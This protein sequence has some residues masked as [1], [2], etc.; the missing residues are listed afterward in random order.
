MLK[1]DTAKS[2]YFNEFLRFNDGLLIDFIAEQE[3]IDKIEAAKKVKAFVDNA[4]KLLSNNKSVDLPGL[5]TLY[6]DVNE[7]IQLKTSD[8][9][10][11]QTTK[12]A[13]PVTEAP[14]R[15]ILFELEKT[16]PAVNQTRAP[17]PELVSPRPSQSPDIKPKDEPMTGHP[18]KE[19]KPVT[20]PQSTKEIQ[21]SEVKANKTQS[22]PKKDNVV[23]D[24]VPTTTRRMVIVGILGVL[25]I[26]AIIYFAFFHSFKKDSGANQNITIGGDSTTGKKDTL[27]KAKLVDVS[28][29]NQA[30]GN[31]ENI[32]RK[33][34]AKT[35]PTTK[36][37][38]NKP[39]VAPVAASKVEAKSVTTGKRFYIIAGTFSL[40]SNADKMFKKLKEQGF[41]PDKI[42]NDT[43]NVFYISFS[44]FADKASATEEMKKIRS[45]GS[46]AWIYAN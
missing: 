16:E 5:G 28:S 17:E 7:K 21:P 8:S 38:D 11:A 33:E 12:P 29:N 19:V 32:K 3:K 23:I 35:E 18:V 9:G 41:Q 22:D 40:E 15:E 39:K 6:L 1:G 44:S 14:P 2:L 34:P 36:V 4:N 25:I 46:E 20:E 43:K 37:T 13:E 30:T 26:L 45:S 27:H 42:R 24:V 10:V 31:K